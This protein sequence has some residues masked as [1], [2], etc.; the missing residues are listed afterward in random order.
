M[1]HRPKGQ[2]PE[3]S[4][5]PPDRGSDVSRVR[6]QVVRSSPGIQTPQTVQLERHAGAP[7]L[8]ASPVNLGGVGTFGRTSGLMDDGLRIE[9]SLEVSPDGLVA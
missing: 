3:S 6:A 4:V 2:R 5:I 1:T 9:T 8:L 7:R